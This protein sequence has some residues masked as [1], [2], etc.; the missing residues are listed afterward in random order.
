MVRIIIYNPGPIIPPI[1]GSTRV[2]HIANTL[3][4][5]GLDIHVID[6]D[7]PIR[8]TAQAKFE[9]NCHTSK[10]IFTSPAFYIHYFIPQY[11]IIE[12]L[13]KEY[14]SKEIILQAEY[15]YSIY[16][17]YLL[18]KKYN[19]P[20][21]LTAHNVESL[22][23][24][25]MNYRIRSK[26]VEFLEK[27]FLPK[28]DHIICVSKHD[29]EIFIKK[30]NIL[31]EHITVAPNAVD[32]EKFKKMNKIDARAVIGVDSTTPIVLFVGSLTYLPNR[33]A[34]NIIRKYLLPKVKKEIPNVKF[35]IVGSGTKPKKSANIIITGRVKDVVPYINAADVCIAPLISGS[36]TRLKILEYFACEKPVVSTSKGCEGI[37]VKNGK[38]IIIADEWNY[39]AKK[40]VLLLEDKST[41][42]YLGRNARK[43]VEKKYNWEVVADKYIKVY[44]KCLSRSG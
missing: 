3:A 11:K 42:N 2:F 43:L 39:F 15:I 20:L 32:I 7:L 13:I 21:V 10:P 41:S 44:R 17:M 37:E 8:R 28:C 4:K 14:N 27:F 5:R 40:I 26:Y 38:N 35:L 12:R 22:L 29:R 16:P 19:I 24:K 1:G 18:K 30:F 31:P 33:Q 23:Y 36:G 9:F 6:I 34:V 25:Q